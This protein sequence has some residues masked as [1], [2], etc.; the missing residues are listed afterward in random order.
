MGQHLSLE[1]RGATKPVGDVLRSREDT[2]SLADSLSVE[3]VDRA[4][5]RPVD[6]VLSELAELGPVELVRLAKLMEQPDDL[7]GMAHS[8]RRELR[9]DDEVDRTP[10]GFRQVSEPPEQG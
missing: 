10:I 9:R 3:P 7:P 8:I 5:R 4:P 6:R 1:L 2:G